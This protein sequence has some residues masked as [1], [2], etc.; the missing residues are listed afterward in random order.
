MTES[1]IKQT[2]ERAERQLRNPNVQARLGKIA[3]TLLDINSSLYVPTLV[4]G[5]VN[6]G[7]SGVPILSVNAGETVNLSGDSAGFSEAQ[8][9][10]MFDK[11]IGFKEQDKMESTLQDRS[12]TM[13]D[14]ASGVVV[15]KQG[16]YET[17]AGTITL[18]GSPLVLLN[19]SSEKLLVPNVILPHE[20]VHVSQDLNKPY[21]PSTG[22]PMVQREAKAYSVEGM[23]EAGLQSTH[24]PRAT[25]ANK[26]MNAYEQYRANGGQLKTEAEQIEF[27][28]LLRQKGAGILSPKIALPPSHSH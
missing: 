27:E 14:F 3:S 20:L 24:E 22:Y 21:K 5:R 17:K 16:K 11:G 1:L 23:I 7:D 2:T 12:F 10:A 8:R 26:V 6:Y 4:D 13:P 18:S 25:K 15:S 19:G 28:N 9:K